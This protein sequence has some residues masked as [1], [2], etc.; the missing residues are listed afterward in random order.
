MQRKYIDENKYQNTIHVLKILRIV[1]IIIGVALIIGGAI[2]FIKGLKVFSNSNSWSGPQ[3]NE[4]FADNFK[5]M[6]GA[7][8]GSLGFMIT[9]V[10]AVM[11]SII[12]H[13][14]SIM[15]FVATQNKP[16]IE[17]GYQAYKPLIK[18]AV[19]DVSESLND[20]LKKED[21]DKDHK[22]CKYCGNVLDND[23][24]FCEYCGKKLN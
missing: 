3:P 23:A 8:I 15:G 5:I 1:L 6:I 12:I 16:I 22:F 14:R 21:P 13:R 18:E 11:F 20:G 10:G 24:E 4:G 9:F 19:K 7:F 2:L 17:E